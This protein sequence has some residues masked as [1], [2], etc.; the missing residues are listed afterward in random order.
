LEGSRDGA[1]NG[2]QD[3]AT[4]GTLDTALDKASEEEEA[5]CEWD[6]WDGVLMNRYSVSHP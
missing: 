2:T 6:D 3:D 4:N 5:K 1:A